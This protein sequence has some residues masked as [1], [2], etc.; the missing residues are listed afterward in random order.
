M[1][2]LSEEEKHEIMERRGFK[3][4]KTG[5]KHRESNLVIHHI[6]RNT[7]NN[8]PENLRVLSTPTAL[9]V[10]GLWLS[11]VSL[12]SIIPL[13]LIIYNPIST[14]MPSVITTARMKPQCSRLFF[15]EFL[16]GL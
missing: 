10:S 5:Q 2:L 8:K 3:S 6:D 4:D 1:G 11:V 9:K 15:A 7:K 12:V 13:A 14:N 16:N